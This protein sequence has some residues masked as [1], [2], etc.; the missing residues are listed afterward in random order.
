VQF[1]TLYLIHTT[2]ASF[3]IQDGCRLQDVLHLKGCF[4]SFLVNCFK[5]IVPLL[6]TEDDLRF[7]FF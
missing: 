5:L 1:A 4:T 7:F 3:S 2:A 6:I